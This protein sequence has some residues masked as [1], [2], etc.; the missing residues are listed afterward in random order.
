M[1]HPFAKMFD[2]ALRKS[3][4][5]DFDNKVLLEAE[6]LKAKGYRVSEIH[7]VLKKYAFGIIDDND[8]RVVREALEEF[9]R[10]VDE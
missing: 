10:Y 2:I 6:K 9:E 7:E 3:D 4:P 1:A 8:A 5:D